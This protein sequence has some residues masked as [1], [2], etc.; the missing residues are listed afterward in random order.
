MFIKFQPSPDKLILTKYLIAS[1]WSFIAFRK[2]LRKVY[3]LV[4]IGFKVDPKIVIRKID[5]NK[6]IIKL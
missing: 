1:R 6:T 4:I 5:K 3:G 2:Q